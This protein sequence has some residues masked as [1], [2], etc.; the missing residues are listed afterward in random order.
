MSLSWNTLQTRL[1]TCHP[2]KTDFPR[3][4]MTSVAKPGCHSCLALQDLEVTWPSTSPPP[5]WNKCCLLSASRVVLILTYSH[6]LLLFRCDSLLFPLTSP[7][8]LWLI[9]WKCS[10]HCEK[11]LS[12]GD[13]T[14]VLYILLLRDPPI[15]CDC[16]WTSD[17]NIQRLTQYVHLKDNQY[18]KVD[19][20]KIE[21]LVLPS[22]WP[23]L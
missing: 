2:I 23:S 9:C 8:E 3:L 11:S 13:L 14:P 20:S 22:K 6:F 21:F 17:L 18:P 12:P 5:P 7:C 19:M 1:W 4:L 15:T 10:R 16:P